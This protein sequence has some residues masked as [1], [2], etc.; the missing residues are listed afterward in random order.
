MTPGADPKL[1]WRGRGTTADPSTFGPVTS[2]T[3][4]TLCVADASGTLPP[5]GP[6]GADLT[7]LTAETCGNG[8]VEGGEECDDG[9]IAAGDC[10]SPSCRVEPAG[11]PCA[12]DGSVCTNDACDGMGACTH[13]V[14]AAAGCANAGPRRASIAMTPGADP[15][16]AWRWRGTTA[17][18]STFGPVTSTTG[19]TLCV[20]DASGTLLAEAQAPQGGVCQNGDPCW[21]P[22]PTGYDYVDRDRTPDGI[23]KITLRASA[24]P[25][26]ARI[27]LKARGPNL[28][29]SSPPYV[30]PARVRL[31]RDDG[32]AC[33][34]ATYTSPSRTTPAG[35]TAKSD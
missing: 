2:T 19:L 22:K 29:F 10:C 28:S 17:D 15:K 13:V 34:D 3:G 1:A 25:A 4:L 20:A 14:P 5:I 30:A 18:P 12:S 6:A 23:E 32:V 24:T 9:N 31:V 21:R 7:A 35:F 11:S 16:L 27:K 26:K 8:T 33:W